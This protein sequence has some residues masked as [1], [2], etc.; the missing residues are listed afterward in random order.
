MSKTEKKRN[1][2]LSSYTQVFLSLP[3]VLMISLLV[4]SVTKLLTSK[5]NTAF[6]RCESFCGMKKTLCMN[7][8]DALYFTCVQLAHQ[9][10]L[11]FYQTRSTYKEK[12]HSPQFYIF[13]PYSTSHFLWT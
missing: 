3:K 2:Y 5:I 9:F 7:W 8:K 6:H 12:D 4:N 1:F 13:F 11:Q 10:Y